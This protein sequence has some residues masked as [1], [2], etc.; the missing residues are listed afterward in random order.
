MPHT[1]WT[2]SNYT[3]E[4]PSTDHISR[5][6]ETPP[7]TRHVVPLSKSGKLRK[8]LRTRHL[9]NEGTAWVTRSQPLYGLA[10]RGRRGA[11]QR[12]R[13]TYSLVVTRAGG[14]LLGHAFGCT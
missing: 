12:G 7:S 8:V 10:T 13:K 14:K 5:P 11:G 6:N 2:R 4:E 1:I 3:P 9:T